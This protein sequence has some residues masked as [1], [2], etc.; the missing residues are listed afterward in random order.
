MILLSP[1]FTVLSLRFVKC[2]THLP[3]AGGSHI[4][5]NTLQITRLH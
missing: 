1:K 5:H 2:V 3:V 4:S